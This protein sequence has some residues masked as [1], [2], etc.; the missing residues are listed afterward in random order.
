MITATGLHHV[1]HVMGMAVS[2]D[3]RDDIDPASITDVVQWLHHVDSTF[4]TYRI[5]SPVSRFGLGLCSTDDLDDEV[6]GVLALCDEMY[7][8]TDGM[9]D[10][11]SV[12]APNGSH[13]DPS[14]LV[15]GWSL[16]RAAE[17]LESHGAANFVVNG[18]G[19]LAVRGRPSPDED[20]G[21]GVRHPSDIASLAAVIGVHGRTAVATSGT[22]ERGAHII[23]PRTGAPTAE[24]ASVTIVGTDLTQ[25]DVWATTVFAMGLDGLTWLLDHRP[26]CEGFAITHD[27]RTFATP[28]FDVLLR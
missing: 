27:G 3:V 20:W 18:G 14:G 1:E 16:E 11:A 24:L 9:F 12:P 4:S 10:I 6:R 28:G 17:L 7:D 22:Y 15:K 21:I 26:E 5:D 25:V 19:D 23:D 8:L 13:L 2:I